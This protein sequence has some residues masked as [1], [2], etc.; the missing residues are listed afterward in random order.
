MPRESEIK[1][2][3]DFYKIMGD[4][5]RCRIIC[6]LRENEMCVCDLCN[7]LSMSK[8]SVSHQLSKMRENGIVKCRREGKEVYYSLDD[9]HVLEILSTTITHIQHKYKG[10]KI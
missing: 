7:V 8:S 3:S 4:P 1:S 10:E 9:A 5:T 6:A 2:I